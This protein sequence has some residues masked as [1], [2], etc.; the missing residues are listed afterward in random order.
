[1]FH[2]SYSPVLPPALHAA[3]KSVCSNSTHAALAVRPDASSS[4]Y[5][6]NC[7]YLLG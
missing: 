7:A 6:R 4:L 5:L 2:T 3:L 1:M